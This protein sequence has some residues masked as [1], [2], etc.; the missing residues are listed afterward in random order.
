MDARNTTLYPRWAD[1]VADESTMTITIDGEQFP[2]KFEVCDLCEG[3]GRH[4]NPAIDEHGLSRE[5]FDQDPDFEQ[6]YH[7]G[8]YDVVCSWCKGR[9]VLLRPATEEGKRLIREI[10]QAEADY[11]AEIAAER[12]MGC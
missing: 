9:R 4:V 3:K 11:R 7:K 12:R 5:D 10:R 2:A 6:N 1:I 8:L